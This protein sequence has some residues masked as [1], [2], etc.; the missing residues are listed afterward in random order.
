MREN[1]PFFIGGHEFCQFYDDDSFVRQQIPYAGATIYSICMVGLF[2]GKEIQE[3]CV[4]FGYYV[5]AS[6]S[7]ACTNT[8]TTLP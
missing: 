8:T 5:F 7:C 1:V 3:V 2:F 4:C 6:D